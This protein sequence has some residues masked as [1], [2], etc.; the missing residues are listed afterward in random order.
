MRDKGDCPVVLGG[1]HLDRVGPTRRC[2]SMGSP[3]MLGKRHIRWRDNPH[4][5]IEEIWSRRRRTGDLTPGHR[6]PADKP[7]W[8]CTEGASVSKDALLH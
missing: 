4:S 1:A 6:M 8:V 3:L 5:I 7:L 2:E